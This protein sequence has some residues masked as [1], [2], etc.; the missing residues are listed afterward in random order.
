MLWVILGNE[1]FSQVGCWVAQG[2][3]KPP[4]LLSQ[5]EGGEVPLSLFPGSA[6]VL[7]TQ[8]APVLLLPLELISPVFRLG[9]RRNGPEV[10]PL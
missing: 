7:E 10:S 8:A 9:S 5:E 1:V 4:V 3:H 6:Q 2:R